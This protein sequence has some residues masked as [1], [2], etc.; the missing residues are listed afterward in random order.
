MGENYHCAGISISSQQ[1]QQ[2]TKLPSVK[3]FLKSHLLVGV[4]F[5]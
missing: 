4:I 1:Q 2:K 5:A 3:L